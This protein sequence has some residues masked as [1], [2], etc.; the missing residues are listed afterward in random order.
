MG[1]RSIRLVFICKSITY[2][3]PGRYYAATVIKVFMAFMLLRYEIKTKDGVR[4]P[5]FR[6]HHVNLPSTTAEIL[7]KRIGS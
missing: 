3:S 4:P 7:L 2:S 1:T 5:N 6:F